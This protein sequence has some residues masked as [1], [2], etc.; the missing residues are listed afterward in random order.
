MGMERRITDFGMGWEMLPASEKS[1]FVGAYIGAKSQ[2]QEYFAPP[3]QRW[4]GVFVKLPIVAWNLSRYRFE[5]AQLF[6]RAR[7]P[8][9]KEYCTKDVTKLFDRALG[10]FVPLPRP[11]R[12]SNI[13]YCD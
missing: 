13:E 3:R 1:H 8:D 11:H 5:V 6:D 2:A 4:G 9:P 7:R 12:A 10:S